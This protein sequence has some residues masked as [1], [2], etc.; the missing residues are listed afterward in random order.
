MFPCM[1]V[2][3]V[4]G[5]K[6]LNNFLIYYWVCVYFLKGRKGGM[7]EGRRKNREREGGRSKEGEGEERE[8]NQ[9]PRNW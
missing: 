4:E 5:M 6:N 9:W 8:E 2:Y 7:K 1:Q 3:I